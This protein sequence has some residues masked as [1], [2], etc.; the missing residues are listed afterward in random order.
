MGVNRHAFSEIGT[1]DG[2][3][4]PQ[5]A[6]ECHQVA[7]PRTYIPLQAMSAPPHPVRRQP[8]TA[9]S[10]LIYA[11]QNA[12]ENVGQTHRTFSGTI[13]PR[14][15]GVIE[16]HN[17]AECGHADRLGAFSDTGSRLVGHR[18]ASEKLDCGHWTKEA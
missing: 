9:Q 15:L 12:Q 10:V 13:P 18:C 5:R 2:G 1:G 17:T 4:S 6:R 7:T 14:S 3:E 11:N 16:R 8:E